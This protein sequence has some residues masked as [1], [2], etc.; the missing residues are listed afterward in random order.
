MKMM[1]RTGILAVV[2]AFGFATTADAA[3]ISLYRSSFHLY[4]NTA[5]SPCVFFGQAECSTQ[6]SFPASEP[7]TSPAPPTTSFSLTQVYTG[8][9]YA[10]WLSLIGGSFILGFDINDTNTAQF[11]TGFT[12]TF[13]GD[14]N[15]VT[16]EYSW[17]GGSLAVPDVSNGVGYADYI[18]AAGCAPLGTEAGSGAN[19]T[20]TAYA[21]FVFNPANVTGI[22]M[23]F[24]M[25][26]VNDGADKIFAIKVTDLTPGGQCTVGTCDV[27][28]EPGSMMLLGT[29]LAGLAYAVRRRRRTS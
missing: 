1:L 16:P 17:A 25:T 9:D 21:P 10:S 22:R 24:N 11:L 20:C 28:P 7:D 13:L 14:G 23:T 27:V 2:A 18:L 6:G 29:G 8:T 3:A 15:D 12:I 26:G 19:A 4:Q 5:N